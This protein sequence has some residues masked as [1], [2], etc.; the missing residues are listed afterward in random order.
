MKKIDVAGICNGLVDIFADV[1]Q[2]DFE[3]LGF[4]KGT[5]RLV[6]ADEQ[7]PLLERFAGTNPAMCSGGS[8]ANSMIVV[9]QLG[10]K[11]AI[12]CN[13]AD[14]AYGRFYRDECLE[15][16]IEMPVSLNKHGATGTVISL[17]T[18]DA[19]RTMRTSLGVCTELSPAHI[20]PR[21]IE[22]SRWVFVEG[23]VFSNSD[24][25]RETIAEVVS[26]AKKSNTK[27]AVTCSDA[28][29]V[30]G[31]GEHLRKT[32]ESTSLIFANEEESAALAGTSDVLAA[33][34]KLKDNFPHVVLTAGPRGAHIWWEGEEIHVPAFPCE[35]R[36]LTGAGDMF[37]G[38]FLHGIN[39]GLSP[40]DAAHRANFLASKVICQVGARLKGNVQ[41]MW[42]SVAA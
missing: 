37:A 23:Y 4:E 32:L 39:H 30:S 11:S 3:P 6:S 22:E 24:A 36:D 1:S 28:W 14:D 31:F 41:Q 25:G 21:V 26:M 8:V 20:S 13:L 17:I 35:P 42:K 10:G 27:I 33:G 7:R 38:S 16:G 15:L 2:A 19:E 29:I 5:M 40:Y 18:P 9:A 34:R 12:C